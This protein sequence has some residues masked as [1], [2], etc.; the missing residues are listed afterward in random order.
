MGH[1][2]GFEC[3]GPHG[4]G[5]IRWGEKEFGGGKR[6]E[7]EENTHE[8]KKSNVKVFF[9]DVVHQVGLSL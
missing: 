3:V 4:S 8:R 1:V 5:R 7:I 9:T 2:R 6:E